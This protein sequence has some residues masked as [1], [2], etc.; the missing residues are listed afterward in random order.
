ME[1]QP[2]FS[3][4]F[5]RKSALPISCILK[6]MTQELFCSLRWWRQAWLA[7]VDRQSPLHVYDSSRNR[8]ATRLIQDGSDTHVLSSSGF[9][10]LNNAL[11]LFATYHDISPLRAL[12]FAHESH[13]VFRIERKRPENRIPA[14]QSG[15]GTELE[16]ST[17]SKER[18]RQF[19]YWWFERLDDGGCDLDDY[20]RHEHLQPPMCKI[21]R[22]GAVFGDQISRTFRYDKSAQTLEVNVK[23][24][25]T[26]IGGSE[27]LKEL[28]FSIPHD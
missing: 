22:D 15:S 25:W 16:G 4:S 13:E 23:W 18:F 1:V 7:T 26:K 3:T 17:D 10:P 2:Y 5:G 6:I 19:L 28:W 24:T 27:E 9:T 12:H 11:W 14:S 8:L 20:V 21:R